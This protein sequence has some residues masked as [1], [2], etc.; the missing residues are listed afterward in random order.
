MIG[1]SARRARRADPLERGG[2]EMADV[3]TATLNKPAWVDLAAKDPGAARDFYAK[4]FGWDIEVNPDPQY[5]GYGRAKVDG[6]D[7]SVSAA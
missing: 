2:T 1:P 5:G 4:L 3:A 6:R 7:A